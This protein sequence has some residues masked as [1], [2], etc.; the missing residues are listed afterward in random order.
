MWHLELKHTT[1]LQSQLT[2]YTSD[3]SELTE[4]VDNVAVAPNT[5]P[6]PLCILGR[7]RNSVFCDRFWMI[8]LFFS[9]FIDNSSLLNIFK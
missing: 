5:L 1:S 8:M 2:T 9:I 4:Q 7:V 3:R 6:R